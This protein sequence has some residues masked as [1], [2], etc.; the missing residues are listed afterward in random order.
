MVAGAGDHLVSSAALYG[1]THTL[2]DVSLRRL[3]IETSFVAADN[4]SAFAKAVAITVAVA[5]SSVVAF[6]SA[7]QMLLPS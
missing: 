5:V 2:L 3:G 1:G 7:L 6:A 4:P